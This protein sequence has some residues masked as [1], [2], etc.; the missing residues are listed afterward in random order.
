MFSGHVNSLTADVIAEFTPKKSA[1]RIRGLFPL[2]ES[3]VKH[4]SASSSLSVKLS[5]L[6]TTS[7]QLRLQFQWRWPAEGTRGKLLPRCFCMEATA[8]HK[9]PQEKKS[10]EAIRTCVFYQ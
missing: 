4:I 10:E 8:T 1:N 3:A 6:D 7:H 5:L 9:G 2:R